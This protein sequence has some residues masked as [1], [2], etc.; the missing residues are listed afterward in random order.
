MIMNALGRGLASL[1]PNKRNADADELMERIDTME[2][3]EEEEVVAVSVSKKKSV[4]IAQEEREVPEPEEDD[5]E[6]DMPA[7]EQD[8]EDEES[9]D[10]LKLVLADEDEERVMPEKP[11]VTPITLD[12]EPEAAEPVA[13]APASA[14]E[15]AMWD[16]HGENVEHIAIEEITVNPLQPR[17]V[18]NPIELEELARSI[19]AYG[20]LQPLVVRKMGDTY[21]LIAG[22]RR[23]RAAKSLGWEKVPAVVR[24]EADSERSRLEL[25]LL[26]NIQR[27]NL[28]PIE[29]ALAFKQLTDE[30]GMS[31]EEIGERLGRSRVAITNTVRLLQLPA[32]VQRG[33]AEGKITSGHA[34][35]ILMIPDPEK[36][37]R[38]YHH[39]ISE[40]LTVRRAEVRARRIQRAMNVRDPQRMKLTGRSLTAQK[41]TAALEDKFGFAAKLIFSETKNRFE[42]FFKAHNEHDVHELMTKLL[43]KTTVDK[44]ERQTNTDD[45]EQPV[46]ESGQGKSSDEDTETGDLT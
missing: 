39:L 22:E 6:D 27:Q 2:P 3:V 21:E 24:I 37:V 36:Q 40:G 11:N 23:L 35:T 12:P 8:E 17:R 45:E 32:E 19:A 15:R 14:P 46:T 26:E 33:L 43:G 44:I 13:E 34:R 10:T 42:V 4:P 9:D 41:Y 5:D 1:I 16:K 25:A 38:F 7:E 20:I 31:H 30:Y 29:E 28:N 18:F